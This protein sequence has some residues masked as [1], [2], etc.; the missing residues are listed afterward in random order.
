MLIHVLFGEAILCRV[1][2]AQDVHRVTVDGEEDAVNVWPAA[3]KLFAQVDAER[4][5]F[6]GVGVAIGVGREPR[7]GR[8]DRSQLEPVMHF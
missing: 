6:V 2:H 5:G 1:A 3:V 8:L 7:D 4:G